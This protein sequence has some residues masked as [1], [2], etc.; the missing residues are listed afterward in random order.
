MLREKN[1]T[2]QLSAIERLAK[3]RDFATANVL[4]S[5]LDDPEARVREAAALALGSVGDETL[6]PAISKAIRDSHVSVRY[7][8]VTA[9]R[10]IGGRAAGQAMCAA[11]SDPDARIRRLAS[12]VLLN[13]E[14]PNACESLIVSPMR[15]TL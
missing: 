12:G 10:E 6:V 11:L 1:P 3:M 9:L 5:A 4:A 13:P 14:H 2:L 15:F 7:A 8:A